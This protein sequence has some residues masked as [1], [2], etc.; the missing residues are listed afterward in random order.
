MGYKLTKLQTKTI[1]FFP[2][3]FA[4]LGDIPRLARVSAGAHIRSCSPKI[5]TPFLRQSV[6][7]SF[8]V[9]FYRKQSQI[10]VKFPVIRKEEYFLT[11][12]AQKLSH[13]YSNQGHTDEKRESQT[14]EE[15]LNLLR[16]VFKCQF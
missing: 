16:Q 1:F 10:V 15:G 2:Q 11:L 5:E 3:T 13:N 6:Y 14:E 9:I 4:S 12:V 7:I 8:Q